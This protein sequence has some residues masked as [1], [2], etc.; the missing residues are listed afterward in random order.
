[1]IA[2]LLF[3]LKQNQLLFQP[4]RNP[5]VVIL[6]TIFI[7]KTHIIIMRQVTKIKEKFVK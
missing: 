1:M 3:I 2:Y 6:Q 7:K 5:H 4:I